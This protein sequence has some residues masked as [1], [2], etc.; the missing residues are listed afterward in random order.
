MSWL[1]LVLVCS[2]GLGQLPSLVQSNRVE[3][4][5]P[6]QENVTHYEFKHAHTFTP[7][8]TLVGFGLLALVLVGVWILRFI[9]LSDRHMITNRYDLVMYKM[10][11][12][13]S[14]LGAPK[15]VFVNTAAIQHNLAAA[16]ACGFSM[17]SLNKRFEYEHL[18]NLQIFNM[19]FRSHGHKSRIK[20][21]HND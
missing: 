1:D 11:D 12:R 6:A 5:F 4:S 18:N 9:T 14:P 13:R 8:G 15:K 19:S 7:P 20:S 2:F 10:P 16:S 21:T 17:S 3:I